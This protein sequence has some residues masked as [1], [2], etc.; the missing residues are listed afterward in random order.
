M[1]MNGRAGERRAMIGDWDRGA[2]TERKRGQDLIAGR[3][4]STYLILMELGKVGSE[5]LRLLPEK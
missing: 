1:G 3:K 2:V 5:A 4:R